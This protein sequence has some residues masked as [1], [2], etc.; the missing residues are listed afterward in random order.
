[1]SGMV[2]Q[3]WLVIRFPVLGSMETH[4]GFFRLP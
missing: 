2:D 3:N 4:K 1:M